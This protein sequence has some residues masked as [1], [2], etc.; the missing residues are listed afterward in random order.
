MS[1]TFSTASVFYL[2]KIAKCM[3]FCYVTPASGH[4][5]RPHINRVRRCGRGL[6]YSVTRDALLNCNVDLRPRYNS[7]PGF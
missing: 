2:T 6:L 1:Q 5:T 7:D 4:K 3:P